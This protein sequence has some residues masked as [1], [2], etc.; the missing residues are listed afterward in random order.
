MSFSLRIDLP[1][2]SY[3]SF[4]ALLREGPEMRPGSLMERALLSCRKDATASVEKETLGP[5]MEREGFSRERIQWIINQMRFEAV[6]GSPDRTDVIQDHLDALGFF[7]MQLQD[8]AQD[9]VSLLESFQRLDPSLQGTLSR[10]VWHACREPKSDPGFGEHKIEEDPQI[11]LRVLDKEGNNCVERLMECLYKMRILSSQI[12]ELSRVEEALDQPMPLEER[13]RE[14]VHSDRRA[15]QDHVS[16][17]V[18]WR[19]GGKE[20]PN[21]VLGD[22]DYGTRMAEEE[23]ARLRPI[24]KEMLEVLRAEQQDLERMEA[25][26][27][28]FSMKERVIEVPK[29]LAQEVFYD[30]IAERYMKDYGITHVFLA[31][32]KMPNVQIRIALAKLCAQLSGRGT[33]ELI[34]N[35]G[36][37]DQ[38][39][40][41]EIAKLC[42]QQDGWGTAERIG[43]FGI[44]D[45]ESLIEIA[46]LCARQNGFRTAERIGN[47]GIDQARQEALI[48]I[49]K[50]CAQQSRSRTAQLIQNFGIDPKNQEEL[51]EIAKL[52]AQQDGW[53]T[54]EHI[55]NFGID[56]AHQEGLIEIA[57]L[58]AQQDG[59]G[60]AEHIRNFGIDPAHQ[61]GL[62]EIAR[63]CAQQD[64]EG[65]AE[66]IRN[67]GIDPAHQEGLIEIA[68]LCAQSSGFGTALHIRK[69]GIKEEKERIEIAKLCTEQS[70]GRIAERIWNFE[71]DPAHQE[72]LIEIASLCAEQ[73]GGTTARC[74]GNFGIEDQEALVEIAKLC[75]KQ[76][77]WGTAEYIRNFGIKDEKESMEIAK[78]CAQQNGFRTAERIGNFGID[79][80]HQEALI[81]IARLCAKNSGLGIAL[82]IRNFGIKEEKERIEIAKLCA[83]ENGEGTA[84]HIRNFGIDPKNQ[85]ALIAIAKLCVQQSRGGTAERIGN[86]GIDPKNQEALIEIAKL[87]ARQNGWITAKLIRR[88]GIDPKNQEALIA[89]AKLCAQQSRGRAAEWIERFEID[90][91]HQKALIEIAK[92][93]ARQNGWITAEVIRRFGI[94]LKNQEALIEIASL[95]AFSSGASLFRD[96][97][98]YFPDLSPDTFKTL[99]DL[100]LVSAV[101]KGELTSEMNKYLHEEFYEKCSRAL[102]RPQYAFLAKNLPSRKTEWSPL[103]MRQL[104]AISYL[105]HEWGERPIP[106]VFQKGYSEA[107]AYRNAALS[108]FCLRQLR[109]CKDSSMFEE[110]VPKTKEG[111]PLVQGLLPMVSVAKW[112]KESRKS[113]DEEKRSIGKLQGCVKGCRTEFKNA[114]SGLMQGWLLACEALEELESLASEQK[115]HILAE[116]SQNLDPADPLTDLKKRL[117]YVNILCREDRMP[118]TLPSHDMTS[119]LSDLI[120]RV[121]QED[122][123]L[124]LRAVTDLSGKYVATLAQM[125]VPGAW[126]TYE[127]QIK[128][129]ADPKVQASFQKTIV[130]ILEGEF[131]AF[132]YQEAEGAQHGAK[133]RKAHPEIWESWKTAKYSRT[134]ELS[135]VSQTVSFSFSTFLEQKYRDGHLAQPDG[136]AR[137]DVLIDFLERQD[138]REEILH[139]CESA[140]GRSEDPL[141]RAQRLLME[142]Y[143]RNPSEREVLKSLFQLEELLPHLSGFEIAND[144]TGLKRG[145]EKRSAE[146]KEV[147]LIDLFLCGTEIAGSCQRID[148][149]PRLNQCLLAYLMDGKNRML[150]VK[151]LETGKILARCLFRLLWDH[152]TGQPVLFQDRIY[153]MPCPANMGE[154]LDRLAKI[155]ATEL[156]LS[157]Y[158][159]DMRPDTV[160]SSNEIVS[161][162]SPA[163]YEYEDASEGVMAEGRF[164]IK[165]LRK[166]RED[167]ATG[168]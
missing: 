133:I 146:N 32:S 88:F 96:L 166:V 167:P 165:N 89:I 94:D 112:L 160:P 149:D 124:D 108:F 52:C 41:I 86:F 13:L 21:F 136:S 101:F 131:Q 10:W 106:D 168:V 43:N 16:Y 83:Q 115:V 132:R 11:L 55:R 2:S 158:T 122:D 111:A 76:D 117:S 63:L 58:C 5:S 35:F 69:F 92:L 20:D 19:G 87:C 143:R 66:R 42:A 34:R 25:D 62:I 125:R 24:F 14:C 145:L 60:T 75:A 114:R 148:G 28:T 163:P 123:Y 164:A 79:P 113:I 142:L 80:A 33:A 141:L 49:A 4:E 93:C 30:K 147:L 107:I 38:E 118:D 162:G 1:S 46:S 85:E 17:Q 6:I 161:L 9:R 156:G 74:I 59:A 15:L 99:R 78:L 70:G 40:L 29:V 50:L 97:D 103:E 64:G 39:G 129:T 7:L 138:R 3:F 65:T 105:M 12:E 154:A 102:E 153:P 48:E 109:A 73:S 119:Y 95:C 126:K 68:R 159:A 130:S 44:E 116:I 155:R 134:E 100:C 47:F 81:E 84:E 37:E 151:D 67:F 57:R 45:Q 51:I 121:V 157:L 26:K 18:W 54:A 72:V 56:P 31:V 128:Q 98:R 8:P 53:G 139:A 36:I 82:Y 77:G 110:A 23:P 140:L 152:T 127:T 120:A 71:I 104:A 27:G 61:E 150:A 137:L 90:P 91:V 135:S 22:R 144:I